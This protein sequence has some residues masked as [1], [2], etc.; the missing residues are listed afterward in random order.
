MQPTSTGL[1]L[2]SDAELY[3]ILHNSRGS[4]YTC[5]TNLGFTRYTQRNLRGEPTPNNTARRLQRYVK[6][7]NKLTLIITEGTFLPN[8]YVRSHVKSLPTFITLWDHLSILHG[9]TT[10][11]GNYIHTHLDPFPRELVIDCMF[12]MLS[13]T[14]PKLTTDFDTYEMHSRDQGVG[15]T[16]NTCQ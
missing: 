14:L 7:P 2:H 15:E 6:Y 12:V 8:I 13:M 5:L 9:P 10:K 4:C 16:S 3:T 11:L 1:N